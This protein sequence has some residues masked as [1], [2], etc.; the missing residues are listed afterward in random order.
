[1]G[2]QL[3]EFNQNKTLVNL[4]NVHDKPVNMNK[5]K[6]LG[7]IQP[8]RSVLL[9]ESSATAEHNQN[10]NVMLTLNDVPEHTRAVLVGAELTAE[11][12]S[13]ACHLILEDPERFVGPDGKTGNTDW[14]RHGVDV[15]GAAPLK[16][17][18]TGIPRAKQQVADGQVEKML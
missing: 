5:G 11:Q 4:I 17:S 1:M 16:V 9:I 10:S 8:V 18:Y 7:S 3:V 2:S 12:T 15:Q 13:D 6:T 14:A